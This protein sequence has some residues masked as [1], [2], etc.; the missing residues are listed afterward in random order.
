MLVSLVADPPQPTNLAALLATL[1]ESQQTAHR[2]DVAVLP[3]LLHDL[4]EIQRYVL[5]RAT[6]H[7]WTQR[8]RIPFFPSTGH[9]RQVAWTLAAEV[10]L[11]AP[12]WVPCGRV[13]RLDFRLTR[14]GEL[15]A[16]RVLH[17]VPADRDRAR[18]RAFDDLRAVMS[19]GWQVIISPMRPC[20]I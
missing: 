13:F 15:A 8:G 10:R 5:A 18:E 3:H 11:L 17:L 12:Y 6:V 2:G 14:L 1:T 19:S 20:L 4:T 16:P 9:Q 7:C